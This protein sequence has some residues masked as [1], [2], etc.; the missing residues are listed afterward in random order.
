MTLDGS[1]PS[2]AW[3]IPEPVYLS[4]CVANE[5]ET[6]AACE[7]IGYPVMLKASWGGGGKGI[8]KLFNDQEVRGV[9]QQVSCSGG[10]QESLGLERKRR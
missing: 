7:R 3:L 8:R 2:P 9:F 4:A 5:E 6:V 10:R 1:G